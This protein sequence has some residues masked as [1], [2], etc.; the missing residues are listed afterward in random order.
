MSRHMNTS[1]YKIVL[2]AFI[3]AGCA[4]ATGLRSTISFPEEQWKRFENPILDFNIKSP[5]IFYDMFFEL[6]YDVNNPPKEFPITVI[7]YT[8]SGE[9]R[10]RDI[11]IRA[12]VPGE[13]ELA[14]GTIR[15]VL[16]REYA[17]AEQGICKFEIE[18]RSSKVITTGIK[19]L[20]ILL[21]KSH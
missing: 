9:M 11:I 14:S 2:L 13:G 10:A 3:L 20:S 7:M 15:L 18:N 19:N 1:F 4:Q 6:E 16:R 8:P 17:F 12:E 21:E 5:G